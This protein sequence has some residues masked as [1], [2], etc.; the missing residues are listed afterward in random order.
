MEQVRL[1]VSTTEP[2]KFSS[3]GGLRRQG[4]RRRGDPAAVSAYLRSLPGVASVHDLHIWGMSTT[5]TALTAHLV[6]P[7]HTVN[8]A[9][10]ENAAQELHERFEIEHSTL[11][12]ERGDECSHCPLV[13]PC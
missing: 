9:F 3:L 4:E 6:I 10:L 5:E 7:D 2:G 13:P 11:Q 1:L 8:D 12:I